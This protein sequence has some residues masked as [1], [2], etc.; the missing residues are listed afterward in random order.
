MLHLSK[1]LT[2]KFVFGF[3]KKMK[4]IGGR[5]ARQANTLRTNY[6]MQLCILIPNLETLALIIAEICVF[7]QTEMAESPM[8]L[9]LIKNVYF[10]GY[11]NCINEKLVCW[12]EYT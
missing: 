9:K 1:D 11:D 5:Q 7:V 6:G 3:C 8:Q 4:A 12:N 10:L 2:H